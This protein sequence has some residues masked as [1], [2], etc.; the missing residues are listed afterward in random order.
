MGAGPLPP[1][2][3]PR[4]CCVGRDLEVKGAWLSTETL[5]PLSPLLEEVL[6]G[7]QGLGTSHSASRHT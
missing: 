1:S 7:I 5:M 3:P 4:L 6:T 2:T